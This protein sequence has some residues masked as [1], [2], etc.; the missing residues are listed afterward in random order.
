FFIGAHSRGPSSIAD[1]IGN[2]LG[3]TGL[4]RDRLMD[5]PLVVLR[6]FACSDQDY[7]F[8]QRVSDGRMV[9]QIITGR[10]R[11]AHDLWAVH[12]WL[13]RT[14]HW[15]FASGQK[16]LRRLL[17]FGGIL[18][19]SDRRKTLLGECRTCDKQRTSDQDAWRG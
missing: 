2:V 17:L 5:I 16:L 10:P 7:K 6:P 3:N 9:A 15:H 13:E 14:E 18:V 12:H 4:Q 8:A 1:R 19:G 11:N